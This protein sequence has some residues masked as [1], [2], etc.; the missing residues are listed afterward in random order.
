MGLLVDQL[1]TRMGETAAE[2]LRRGASAA[3][4]LGDAFREAFPRPATTSPPDGSGGP[5]MAPEAGE[6]DTTAARDAAENT[7]AAVLVAAGLGL[8]VQGE[9]AAPRRPAGRRRRTA[10]PLPKE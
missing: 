5:E 6:A 2:L 9:H 3:R 8:A 7:L 4:A 10:A 1:F